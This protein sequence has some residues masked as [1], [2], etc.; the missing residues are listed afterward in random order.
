MRLF[1]TVCNK[2]LHFF[3]EMLTLGIFSKADENSGNV[4]RPKI[5]L[6][7]YFSCHAQIGNFINFFFG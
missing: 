2:R 6:T 5:Y 1:G 3:F 7:N 4:T